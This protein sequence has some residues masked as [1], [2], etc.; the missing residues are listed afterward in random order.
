MA[1]KDKGFAQRGFGDTWRVLHEDTPIKVLK[2]VFDYFD[3]DQNGILDKD[4]FN[5]LLSVIGVEDKAAQDACQ[6][7][8]DKNG[9]G[10][11]SKDEFY[12]WI[13]EDK[14]QQLMYDSTKFRVLCDI[15]QVFKSCDVDGDNTISWQEFKD[16]MI[17]KEQTSLDEA[18][19][20]F[21]QID[22]N[23][24]GSITFQEYWQHTQT[25][26]EEERTSLHNNP[27][28]KRVTYQPQFGRNVFGNPNEPVKPKPQY[29]APSIKNNPF[30][31]PPNERE[32]LVRKRK[33][34]D[35]FGQPR[36]VVNVNNVS[37]FGKP[38]PVRNASNNAS[39]FSKGLRR[40][41][42][43]KYQHKWVLFISFDQVKH[44][45]T[46]KVEDEVTH[47]VWYKKIGKHEHYGDMDQE[48]Y[49]LG[50]LINGGNAKY[51]YPPNGVGV[52]VA[53]TKGTERYYFTAV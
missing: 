23:N 10:V 32:K 52:Q 42:G 5:T 43:T 41:G 26:E 30:G 27:N 50:R 9:D 49:R 13:K 35:R 16:F 48:F 28:Q 24:D 15:S 2:S 8:A 36:P 31:R 7:L 21:K 45:I 25:N 19:A 53:L 17:E 18:R 11:I 22:A 14:I 1:Y 44:V 33:D 39:T 29:N 6:L 3:Q 20:L 47:G 40:N 51:M 46:L 12:E 4:E 37:P 38:K 34:S